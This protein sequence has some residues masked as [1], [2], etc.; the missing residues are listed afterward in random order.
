MIQN[1]PIMA[2]VVITGW[3]SKKQQNLKFKADAQN[4]KYSSIGILKRNCES[5]FGTVLVLTLTTTVNM[6]TDLETSEEEAGRA[7][8]CRSSHLAST[9]R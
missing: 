2:R 1:L 9:L 6:K 5:V 4:T 8:C 7:L 3:Y